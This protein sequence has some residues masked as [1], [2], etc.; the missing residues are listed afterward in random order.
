MKT[1]SASLVSWVKFIETAVSYHYTSAMPKTRMSIAPS[2]GKD[3]EQLE[4]LYVDICM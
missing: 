2:V 1:C 4:L 3:G